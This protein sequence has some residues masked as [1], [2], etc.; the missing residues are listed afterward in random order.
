MF[1]NSFFE[2]YFLVLIW[3][4]VLMWYKNENCYIVL[5]STNIVTDMNQFSF[6]RHALERSREKIVS[7]PS[8][9]ENTEDSTGE[10]LYK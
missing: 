1:D 5:K 9:S 7:G 6:K 8:T 3:K 4:C 2:K 10:A